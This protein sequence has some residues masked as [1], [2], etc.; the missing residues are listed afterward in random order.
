[1]AVGAAIDR[2]R[3][4]IISIAFGEPLF[5]HEQYELALEAPNHQELSVEELLL[6]YAG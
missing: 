3:L 2:P 1:M 4:R 5:A 6:D